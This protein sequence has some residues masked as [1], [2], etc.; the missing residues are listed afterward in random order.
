[1]GSCSYTRI[2]S[3]LYDAALEPRLWPAALQSVAE[4]L[5]AVGA[6]Y[7]VQDKRTDRVGWISVSGPCVELK[8]D[9]VSYYSARDPYRPILD[10]V[11]S[12]RW[13]R[14]SS[15]LPKSVLRGNEWYNDF[16]VKSGVGDILGAQLFDHG[17]CTARFGIHQGIRQ[18]PLAPARGL[19]LPALF[20]ALSRAARLHYELRRLS[21]KSA[22]AQRALD[23]V[24]TGL[25]IT[26]G[27]AR[28]IEMNR[29][30]ERAISAD[31]G[32]TVRHGRL[33]ARRVFETAKLGKLIAAAAA[34][35]ET[36][37][38]AGRMLIGRR[39]N[40]PAFVLTAT[41]IG[42]EMAGSDHAL[43][44]VLVA[45]PEQHPPSE[46]ELAELFGFSPAE[47][48]LAA[49][50]MRGMRLRD[51]AAGSDVQ[52]TTLRTQLSSILRKA[53]VER[54]ADLVRVLASTRIV[55]SDASS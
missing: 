18:A 10:A 7:V 54:Q 35:D 44:M 28:V 9:Y 17:S 19:P 11:P 30:A 43:A 38:R 42:A 25:I 20:E 15:C 27:E 2:V 41:P 21:W 39:G 8:A 46:K 13:V 29:A 37:A 16:V 31:G 55:A 49:A 48:R 5:G 24:A 4:A 26:D 14:L 6:A 22:V 34:R 1:M 47:S 33:C 51:I 23:Q 32:L 36:T 53:G 52:I 45:D 12:G 3:T 40:G 50:L